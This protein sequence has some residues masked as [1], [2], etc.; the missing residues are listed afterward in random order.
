MLPRLGHRPRPGRCR[1][2]RCNLLSTSLAIQAM[3][4]MG[5]MPNPATGKAEVNLDRAKHYIDTIDL[6]LQKTAGT[7]NRGRDRGPREPAL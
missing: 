7:P 1:P 3:M 2:R 6:L 5:G 4:A